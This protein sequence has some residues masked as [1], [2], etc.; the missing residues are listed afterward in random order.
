MGTLYDTEMTRMKYMRDAGLLMDQY[1]RPGN[2][3]V[4]LPAFVRRSPWSRFGKAI[5]ADRGLGIG[6]SHPL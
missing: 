4:T 5:L 6:Y 3:G 2:G 1:L